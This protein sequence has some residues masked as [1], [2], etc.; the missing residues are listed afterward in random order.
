MSASRKARGDARL[1]TL[2]PEL[3][4]EIFARCNGGKYDEVRKWLRAEWNITTSV[5]ALSDF[6][7][8]HALQQRF[9]RAESHVQQLA[10]MIQGSG[11]KVDALSLK[12]TMNSIFLSLASQSGDF[13]TFEAAFKLILKAQ[14]VE[15][16]KERIAI[17]K[18]K[19]DQADQ[20]AQ[21]AKNGGLTKEER[22][23]QIFELF[24]K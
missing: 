24:A 12:E 10:E 22:Q 18:R 3:Q 1:K 20:A 6:Y 19:A 14:Q 5:G 16:E 8:W 23:Q 15:N 7:S 9:T 11:L 4:A 21:I 13:G 17:L 2:K